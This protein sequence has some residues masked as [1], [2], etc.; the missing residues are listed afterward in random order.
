MLGRKGTTQKMETRR[1]R[2]KDSGA[3][4]GSSPY[5]LLTV[6]APDITPS[7]VARGT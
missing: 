5:A 4:D 7:Q 6:A 3:T 2:R 1:V